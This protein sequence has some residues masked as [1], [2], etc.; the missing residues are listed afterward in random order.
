MNRKREKKDHARHLQHHHVGQ[1]PRCHLAPEAA[2]A[3]ASAM[4]PPKPGSV[5]R[6]R[7]SRRV[8][9][10]PSAPA[11]SKGHRAC[12][13]TEARMW[14]PQRLQRPASGPTDPPTEQ[15]SPGPPGSR[16]RM[17]RTPSHSF[18]PAA[19]TLRWLLTTAAPR[20]SGLAHPQHGLWAAPAGRNAWRRWYCPPP[21]KDPH[22]R[23]LRTG[24]A[25][26]AAL[27]SSHPL[28]YL[29]PCTSNRRHFF[30]LCGALR[31]PG[32]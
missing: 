7:A 26:T 15:L 27:T 18:S 31:K 11:S 21:T 20:I 5:P 4:P 22:G 3:S 10:K 16:R 17:A 32:S 24:S 23:C 2:L 9:L 25:A 30:P 12:A 8:R 13:N 1:K 29:A 14:L 28:P 6:A 19:R